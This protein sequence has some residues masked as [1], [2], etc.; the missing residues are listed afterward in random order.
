ME[1]VGTAKKEAPLKHL[2][3]MSLHK[4][5]SPL[6]LLT[7]EANLIGLQQELKSVISREC[8]F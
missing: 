1:N 4:G 6:N 3:Q 8:F 7:S 2:E 5:R